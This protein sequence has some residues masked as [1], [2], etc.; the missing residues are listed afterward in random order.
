MRKFIISDIHGFGNVYYSMMNYLDNINSEEDIELYINGN[1]I[2]Y[3]YESADI[4]LDIKRRIN[5][6]NFKIIYLGGSQEL[7]MYEFFKDEEKNKQ[8]TFN[9]WFQYGGLGTYLDLEDK[10]DEYEK[11]EIVDLISNLSV[12]H[13]FEE[14]INNK[15]IVLV[16]ASCPKIVKN[17]CNLLIKEN[18]DEVI[19]AVWDN[20]SKLYVHP[21]KYPNFNTKPSSIGNKNYFTITGYLPNNNLF[22]FEYDYEHN[23]L[24]INGGCLKYV[25]GSFEFDHFPLVEVMGNSLRILT[26]NSNNEITHG[27]LYIN[28]YFLQMEENVLNEERSYL[29]KNLKVKKLY[30]NEDNVVCYK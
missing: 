10:V 2:D 27:I 28:G 24:N 13:K 16:H 19:D 21:N 11:H 22:G 4:L 12:Y 26:F 23:Y 20:H 1:L 14:R 15:P 8:N 30:L 17:H 7:L 3:G 29:N 9:T 5:E 25:T 18:S 6:K